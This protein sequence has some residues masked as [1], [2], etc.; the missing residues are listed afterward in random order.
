[1]EEVAQVAK[2]NGVVHVLVTVLGGVTAGLNL[3]RSRL[4]RPTRATFCG[5]DA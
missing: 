5:I 4:G 2:F 3:G 1:M